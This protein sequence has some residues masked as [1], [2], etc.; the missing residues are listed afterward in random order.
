MCPNDQSGSEQGKLIVSSMSPIIVYRPATAV[1][2]YGCS[3]LLLSLKWVIAVSGGGYTGATSSAGKGVEKE[4]EEDH[5]AF[6]RWMIICEQFTFHWKS[7]H[8]SGEKSGVF[9]H[10]HNH[11]IR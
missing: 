1:I 5:R 3:V 4:A 2:Y 8:H 6:S 10:N 11:W 9:V 7:L